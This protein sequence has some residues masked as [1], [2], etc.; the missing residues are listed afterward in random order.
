MEYDLELY[1]RK[2]ELLKVL[3]HPIRLCIVKGLMEHKDC[4]VTYMKDCLKASQSTISQHLAKLKAANIVKC[5]RNG[6]EI[7][8]QLTDRRL[9]TIIKDLFAEK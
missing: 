2:S 4:N 7:Y 6:N 1:E 5:E 3:A 9:E 8:Y